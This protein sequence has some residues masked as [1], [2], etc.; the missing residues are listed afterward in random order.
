MKH[1]IGIKD[2]S[3]S[4]ISSI[5]ELGEVYREKLLRDRKSVV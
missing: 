1:L 4:E 3:I 2:L 5:L